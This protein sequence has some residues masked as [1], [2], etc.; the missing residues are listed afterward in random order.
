MRLALLI[1][2]GL[3]LF[4][5]ESYVPHPFPWVRV[6]LGN[7]TTLL[8]LFALGPREAIVVTVVRA[9]LGPLILGTLLTPVFV[10]SLG[11]GLAG[12]ATMILIHRWWGGAFSVVGISV[13]GALAHNAAQLAL[14]YLLFV[15]S[16]ALVFLFPLLPVLSAATGIIT[17]LLAHWS[18]RSVAQGWRL[19]D[20]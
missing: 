16:S 9:T 1:S 14:A 2:V 18:L 11:G 19:R 4:V 20:I 8:A 6:G 13:W 15:R 10:F 7:V 3:V 12:A 17:G 5:F